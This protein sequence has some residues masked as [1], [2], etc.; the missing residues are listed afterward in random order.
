M[1]PAKAD[2]RKLLNLSINRGMQFRMIGKISLILFAS[3]LLSGL[4]FFYFSNQ[5]ITASFQ[6]FH[7]K[8]RNFLDFLLPVILSSVLISL[9]IG[10]LASLFFPKPIAGALY[11]IEEDLKRIIANG[12]LSTPIQL[13]SG[14]QVGPVAEQINLLLAHQE[15]CQGEMK[16]LFA[17]LKR[18][19]CKDE[20]PDRGA[21]QDLISRMEKSSGDA[22]V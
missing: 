19:C 13:R 7:I 21:L 22:A 16:E 5:E 14:D 3:Q 20:E 9:L 15:R 1:S 10:F 2:K 8:A 12:D 4:I 11:R 18:H 17:E 6:M